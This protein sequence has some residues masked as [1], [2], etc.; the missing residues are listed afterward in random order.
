VHVRRGGQRRSVQLVPQLIG[1]RTEPGQ[2][3]VEAQR[4]EVDEDRARTQLPA[5]PLTR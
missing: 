3:R 1:Q 5:N 2:R 4:V